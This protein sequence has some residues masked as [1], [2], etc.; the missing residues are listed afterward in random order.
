[1]SLSGGPSVPVRS[2]TTLSSLGGG[3]FTSPA[4][5]RQP[6]S[7]AGARP[8]ASAIPST[9]VPN[10]PGTVTQDLARPRPTASP[11]SITDADPDA[12]VVDIHV[13][14]LSADA[15]GERYEGGGAMTLVLG[16][17]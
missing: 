7:S 4:P 13:V 8:S 3:I 5:T 2:A 9:F 12:V 1:M 14:H 11:V 15:M 10:I 16:Q 6:A 17:V